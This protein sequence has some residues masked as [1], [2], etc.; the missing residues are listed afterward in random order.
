MIAIRGGVVNV[1]CPHMS[2]HVG[3]YQHMSACS[4][5]LTHASMQNRFQMVGIKGAESGFTCRHM[6]AHAG[7]STDTDTCQHPDKV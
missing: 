1:T 4:N 5:V 3:I 6:S 7:M 2:A